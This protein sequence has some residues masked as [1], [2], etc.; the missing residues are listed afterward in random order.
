MLEVSRGEEAGLW[1]LGLELGHSRL[2][3]LCCSHSVCRGGDV[4]NQHDHVWGK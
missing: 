1:V 4:H 3:P 2:Y